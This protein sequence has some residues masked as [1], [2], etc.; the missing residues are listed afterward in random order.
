[1][2]PEKAMNAP[3]ANPIKSNKIRRKYW[4]KNKNYACVHSLVGSLIGE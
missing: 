2:F 1:M 3:T 4:K